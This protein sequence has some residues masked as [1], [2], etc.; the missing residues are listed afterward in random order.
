MTI[1]SAIL[2]LS[3]N[4]Y[5][6]IAVLKDENQAKA[7]SK[8]IADLFTRDSLAEM[9]KQMETYWPIPKDEIES[10]ERKTISTMNTIGERYGTPIGNLKI[11]ENRINDFALKET[12]LIRYTYHALRII[13]IYYRNNSGWIINSFTW[14]DSF[15]EELK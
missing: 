8:R 6:Q 10:L 15:Q 9:F 11:R 5:G 7:L 3:H 12:Y 2:L 4:I 14:D 1:L 13:V